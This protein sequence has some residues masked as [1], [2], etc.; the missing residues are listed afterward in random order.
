[1]SQFD[2]ERTIQGLGI[3]AKATLDAVEDLWAKSPRKVIH[4]TEV[5]R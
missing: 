1:M 2:P 4:M 5:V 3:S